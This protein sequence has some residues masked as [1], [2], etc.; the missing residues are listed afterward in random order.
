MSGC[1]VLH[2]RGH[3][4]S[5]QEL[6]INLRSPLLLKVCDAVCSAQEFSC[7]QDLCVSEG[8]VCDFTD[9][10]GDYSD[11]E[12]CSGYKRCG[13]EDGFCDLMQSSESRWIRTT[14]APGLKHDHSNTSAHFLSLS[15]GTRTSADLISP[16]FLPTETC[17]LRDPQITSV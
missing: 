3:D 13:F 6:K 15:P 5:P 16:F 10:C 4:L 14:E 17:Q 9:D 7:S 2:T 12:N 11:E 1:P 8:S